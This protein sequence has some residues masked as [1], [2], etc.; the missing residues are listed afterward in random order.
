[1]SPTP[2][3][4]Y[5]EV[6]A[7]AR[8]K[9]TIL[10]HRAQLELTVTAPR[11]SLAM[12]EAMELKQRCIR[13]LCNHGIDRDEIKEG[14][15][16]VDREW[17]RSDKKAQQS[18]SHRLLFELDDLGRLQHALQALEPLFEGNSRYRPC[19]CTPLQPVVPRTARIQM[20]PCKA[21]RFT[22]APV[23]N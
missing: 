20:I 5:L 16:D 13:L 8:F 15:S 17:W 22:C 10:A 2:D 3:P 19:C 12:E 6:S 21:V 11:A 9:R 4:R 1:M 7:T 23:L 14:G 18:A